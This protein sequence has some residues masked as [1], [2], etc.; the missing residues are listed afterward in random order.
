MDGWRWSGGGGEQASKQ[1]PAL[2]AL[3]WRGLGTTG[4]CTARG[5]RA[6]ANPSLSSVWLSGSLALWPSL[7]LYYCPRPHQIAAGQ[8]AEEVD[9][10][11]SRGS[12]A[13]ITQG[14][15]PRRLTCWP[16]TAPLFCWHNNIYN[17]KRSVHA[18]IHAHLYR[19]TYARVCLSHQQDSSVVIVDL[20]LLLLL[21]LLLHGTLWADLHLESH[22]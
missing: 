1:Q 3:F 8:P 6:V 5:C 18:Y 9:S 2:A 13:A 12:R 14:R 22:K 7:S 20:L 10:R 11:G 15:H 16:E 21:L 19:C 17:K 4:R